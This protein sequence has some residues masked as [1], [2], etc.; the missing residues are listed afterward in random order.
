MAGESSN[1]RR[2]LEGFK[3]STARLS[4]KIN[5]VSDI[6]KDSN[7][8]ALQTQIGELAKSTRTV[9]DSGEKLCVCIDKFFTIAAEK[10]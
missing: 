1:L 2:E 7:Y 3:Q 8:A 4:G 5:G 6:W 10:V 9:I